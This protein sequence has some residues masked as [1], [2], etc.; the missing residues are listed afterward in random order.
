MAAAEK[1]DDIITQ[2]VSG[3]TIDEQIACVRKYGSH[4]ITPMLRARLM[5][6]LGIAK[7]KPAAENLIVF[8]CYPLFSMPLPVRDYLK[9]L[10]AIGVDYTYLEQEYCCLSTVRHFVSDADLDQVMQ[11]SEEFMALNCDLAR[12]KGA[13]NI[14]YC[15]IGCVH[16]AKHFFSNDAEHHMYYFEL[17]FDK[18]EQKALKLAPITMGYYEGCKVTH[19][20]RYPGVRIDWKRCRRLLGS[21]EGLKI[22]DLPNHLCCVDN[23]GRIVEAAEKQKLDTILCSCSSCYNQV[24]A[25]AGGKVRVKFLTELLLE[26]V[27][28]K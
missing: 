28:V 12:R 7:P 5:H 20:K 21:I 10:D 1:M 24:R 11:A 15:C 3:R 26:A 16:L 19:L 6:G 8:G 27:G 18:I 23:P 25:A 13:Q 9:L 22:V 4:S 2:L 17:L 14:A